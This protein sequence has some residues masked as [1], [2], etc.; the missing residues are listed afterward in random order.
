MADNPGEPHVVALLKGLLATQTPALVGGFLGGLLHMLAQLAGPRPWPPGQLTAALTEAALAWLVGAL[1]GI[2]VGPLIA[3]WMGLEVKTA[4]EAVG[5]VKVIVAVI[6][7]KAL[8][9]LRDKVGDV[10]GDLIKR[11]SGSL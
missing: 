9:I 6:A 7:W 11:K 5:G 3:H 2:Y 10:L 8:P 4:P 1:C